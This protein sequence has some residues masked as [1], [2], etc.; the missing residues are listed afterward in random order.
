MHRVGEGLVVVAQSPEVLEDGLWDQVRRDLLMDIHGLVAVESARLS[1][2]DG[3][4]HATNVDRIT[5]DNVSELFAAVKNRYL[6]CIII[7]NIEFV[8]LFTVSRCNNECVSG[9]IESNS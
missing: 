1:R 3:T 6:T 8:Q 7:D 9:L 5:R 2:T 4:A